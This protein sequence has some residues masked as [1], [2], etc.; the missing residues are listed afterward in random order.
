MPDHNG[1]PHPTYIPRRWSWKSLL[2]KDNLTLAIAAISA[3]ASVA[4]V[5]VAA[6]AVRQWNLE[7][8]DRR[9][10]RELYVQ[11]SLDSYQQVLDQAAKADEFPSARYRAGQAMQQLSAAGRPVALTGSHVI[12]SNTDLS[13]LREVIIEA[14]TV[15]FENV[16]A[17]GFSAVIKAE[18]V[19]FVRTTFRNSSF[20]IRER[21][22]ALRARLASSRDAGVLAGEVQVFY[23]DWSATHAWAALDDVATNFLLF[24]SVLRTSGLRAGSG[25]VTLTSAYGDGLFLGTS[26]PVELFGSGLDTNSP[27]LADIRER[28]SGMAYCIRNDETREVYVDGGCPPATPPVLSTPL[29]FGRFPYGAWHLAYEERHGYADVSNA[30][31]GETL[32]DRAY[33]DLVGSS[34]AISDETCREN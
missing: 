15:E 9:V 12:I 28:I 27:S 8:E 2:S 7:T 22:E 20:T 17:N 33:A 30:H 18:R 1:E 25:S 32:E 11:Q 24:R 23:S 5:I 6:V 31:Q 4:S 19:S 29:R 10:A 16:S 13:C 21:D 3:I 14:R 26:G 34:I